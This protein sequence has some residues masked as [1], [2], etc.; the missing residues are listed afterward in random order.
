[1]GKR[2]MCIRLTSL[3]LAIV[4]VLFATLAAGILPGQAAGKAVADPGP[5]WQTAGQYT[6]S[7]GAIDAIDANTAWAVG[8]TILKTS[9]GGT[10]WV[11]QSGGTNYGLRAVS[12]VDAN[13]AWAVGYGPDIIIKTNDG[14]NVWFHQVAG[15]VEAFAQIFGSV[16]GVYVQ[17]VSAV[18]ANTAWV[19]GYFNAVLWGQFQYVGFILRTDDGGTNWTL[20]GLF[21]DAPN[22][23]TGISAADADT[24]WVT[25]VTMSPGFLPPQDSG[26]FAPVSSDETGSVPPGEGLT[27]TPFSGI[28]G[29]KDGGASWQTQYSGLAYSNEVISTVDRNNVWVLNGNNQVIR[30]SNGGATWDV[31]DAGFSDIKDLS[32]ADASTAW[33]VR[34]SGAIIKS[35]DGGSTWVEQASGYTGGL[36][37]VHAVDPS[38]AWAL[39]SGLFLKTADGGDA[40]PDIVSVAPVSGG[41][42]TQV[43]ITGCDF[44]A[45]PADAANYVSFGG[46]KPLAADYVSW[47]DKQIVVKV[48]AGAVDKVA[49]TA[50]TPAGTSN[51]KDFT[52][53]PEATVTSITPNSGVPDTVVDI[54]DLAGTGF[55]AG[56][57]VRLEMGGTI[58]NASDVV[59]TDTKITCKFDLT[60][61]PVGAYDVVVKNPGGFEAKLPGGFNVTTPNPCGLGGSL[62]LLM[63]GLTLGL[64]S[65]AG[66]TRVRR[67]RRLSK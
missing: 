63:L 23:I 53:I 48:P 55:K 29:T 61:A 27:L 14:G 51:P 31:H 22:V 36:I 24:A 43:T 21:F 13:T 34:S 62:G 52:V 2:T 25:G 6:K 42:G 40:G 33:A 39:G 65:L 50:T 1:M 9:N 8:N 15:V 59:I 46:V 16:Y 10:D 64:I 49:V 67:K 60:A 57:T 37:G 5:G 56:A 28:L 20:Q 41:V 26:E 54:T 12:A 17:D 47:A 19:V 30:T 44:G 3:F 45:G 58:I 4:L 32:A 35:I 38:T 66:S 11:D 7:V 18:D